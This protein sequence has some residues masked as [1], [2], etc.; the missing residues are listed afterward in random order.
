MIKLN[1]KKLDV[2]GLLIYYAKYRKNRNIRLSVEG[3]GKIRLTCPLYVSESEIYDFVLSKENWIKKSLEKLSKNE[4]LSLKPKPNIHQLNELK[5][6]IFRYL[7][8][9]TTLKNVDM[10]SIKLRKMKTEWGNCNYID[11]ILTFNSYLYYMNDEFI[12]AI[13]VHEFVHL[14]VHN[15][16]SKFYTLVLELLPN[17]KSIIKE[18]K[19]I[20][21]K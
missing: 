17:Y 11:R 18:A 21:L 14:F 6:K 20:S 16:S 10:V 9:Y 13:V 19:Y 4:N 12:N 2:N 8:K 15:H 7:E 5:N 1:Y 3:N